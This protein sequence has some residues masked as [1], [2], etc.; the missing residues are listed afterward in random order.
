VR[1]SA[2]G[3]PP[4]TAVADVHRCWGPGWGAEDVRGDGFVLRIYR[5]NGAPGEAPG[6]VV[7]PGSTGVSA[8]APTA[9]LLATHGYVAAVL[10]Y[11]QEPG[12][13]ST[14]RQIPV[15]AI[16]AGLRAFAALPGV[17]PTRDGRDLPYVRIR[18]GFI[19]S[20]TFDLKVKN[21]P[22][23]RQFIANVD[24]GGGYPELIYT[25]GQLQEVTQVECQLMG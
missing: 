6:V 3:A 2:D 1:V 19:V 5:P 8:M 24:L 16:L 25:R 9:A 17:D 11:M 21:P 4:G 13:P 15:E 10:G 14:F 18:A 7:V 23:V 20:D 12:L 22:A